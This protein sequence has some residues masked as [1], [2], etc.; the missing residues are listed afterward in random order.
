[1]YGGKRVSLV[2]GLNVIVSTQDGPKLD[3][4]M[5]PLVYHIYMRNHRDVKFT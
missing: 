4:N 2:I 3:I 5:S 1:M